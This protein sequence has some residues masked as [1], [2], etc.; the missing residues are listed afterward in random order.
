LHADVRE[1]LQSRH[2]DRDVHGDGRRQQH[3]VG[4]QTTAWFAVTVRDTT[5]PELHLP[6][7]TILDAT[8]SDGATVNF[9]ASAVDVYDPQPQFE[10]APASGSLFAPGTTHVDCSAADG[11]GNRASGSFNVTVK[12]ADLQ[13][14]KSDS[15]TEVTPGELLTYSLAFTNVGSDAS[16]V[17][18]HETVPAG[19][20]FV[21]ESSDPRWICTDV[22]AGSVCTL[23]V[24]SLGPQEA[25]RYSPSTPSTGRL[26]ESTRSRTSRRSQTMGRK[27]SNVRPTTTPPAMAR[28]SMLPRTLP[29]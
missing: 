1:L 15:R 23:E 24:G 7:D 20:S 10:C 28:R 25:L 21:S 12:L 13:L 3:L 26:Q 2:D 11:E 9:D 27:A 22:S 4:M 29:W 19:T 18:L 8:G 16:G 6:A 14:S 17:T 5:A